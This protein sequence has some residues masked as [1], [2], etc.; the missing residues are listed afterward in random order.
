MRAAVFY[1]R[2]R[3]QFLQQFNRNGRD[4]LRRLQN[5][6]HPVRPIRR[7]VALAR[8]GAIHLEDPRGVERGLIHGDNRSVESGSERPQAAFDQLGRLR[9]VGQIDPIQQ[10]GPI[11]AVGKYRSSPSFGEQFPP[12]APGQLQRRGVFG[13]GAGAPGL[14]NS[15]RWCDAG[16]PS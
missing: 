3:G 9:I 6:R 11:A 2:L 8:G 10:V 12:Y 14:K 1:R 15:R 16:P 4:H 13:I 5:S 7:V